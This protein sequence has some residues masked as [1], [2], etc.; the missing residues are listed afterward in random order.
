[1][2]VKFYAGSWEVKKRWIGRGTY[3]RICPKNFYENAMNFDE[4][5]LF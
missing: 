1:M 4:P 2:H 3:L 5:F